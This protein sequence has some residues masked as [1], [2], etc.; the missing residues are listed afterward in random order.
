MKM[1]TGILSSGP[2]ALSMRLLSDHAA[3]LHHDPV[4]FDGPSQGTEKLT[5]PR[6]FDINNR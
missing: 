4:V 2:T 3:H 6:A 1:R 5:D